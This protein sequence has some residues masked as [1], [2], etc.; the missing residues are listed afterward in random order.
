[1]NYSRETK[2]LDTYDLV[3]CGGGPAGFPAALA[4]ARRGLKVIIIEAK[5][6]LGGTGTTSMVSHWLGG[7]KNSGEWAIG[8]IYREL[9]LEAT[10]R[11]IAVLPN[12]ADY[13]DDQYAPHGIHKGQLLAGVPFDPF[14]MAPFLEEIV[15]AAGVEIRYESWVVDVDREGDR[16][17]NVLVAGKDGLS[18][19]PAKAFVDATGDADVAAHAGVDFEYG[20]AEGRPLAIS[21][22][23]HLERVDEP[24]LMEY[25]T[26]EDDPRFFKKLATLR[27]RGTECFNYDMIIFVK[28]TRD[29][30]FMIN[31]RALPDVYGT[32]PES[33]TRAYITE[34]K[35]VEPTIQLFRDH[36][37]GC[38]NIELRAVASGL[39]VRESRR[40]NAEGHLSVRDI[41]EGTEVRDSIGFT[42]YGWDINKG[43][44]DLD[45]KKLEKPELVPI[46]Y[47]VMVPKGVSNLICPGRAINCERVVLGPM[48]VQAPIMAMGE[49]AGNAAATAIGGNVAFS[50]VDTDRLRNELSDSDCIV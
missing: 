16:I 8:G 11:G 32:D 42:A 36:W 40:I 28:M 48:R 37:P 18:L 38:K 7:R 29:G 19:L 17:T 30:Y 6:Q 10:R 50:S 2:I 14:L 12:P 4:A 39:G 22:I 35:K 23:I 49:A 33:R 15:E 21:L 25:V 1:M 31:G 45:P 47:S 3:V 41:V 44:G 13:L 9:S 26:R 46:P 5:H 24:E 43:A 20:D 34:R 27:N